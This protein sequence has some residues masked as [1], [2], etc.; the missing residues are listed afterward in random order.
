[1][2][3][4]RDEDEWRK[5][6][7]SK[8]LSGS[9][10][11]LIDNLRRRLESPAMS[12]A[13]TASIWEDRRLGSTEMVHIPV[14]CTWVATGNNPALSGEIA[15]R[16]VRIRLD[17]KVDR[18]WLRKDFRHPDL[19]SWS[20]EHR[21]DL[22]WAALTLGRAWLA[23]RRPLGSIA[24]GT[25]ENWARVIGGVLDVAKIPGFLANREDFYE[26]SDAEGAAWRAF[27]AAWWEQYGDREVGVSDLW[28]LLNPEKGD[29]IDLA[30]GDGAERS[31]RTRLGKMLRAMRDRQFDGL[32]IMA[33]GTRMRAQLWRLIHTGAQEAG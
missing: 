30:V 20:A 29:P 11:I 23:A 9:S 14:Q 12:A 2:T 4:G 27:V 1:M 6:I 22:I 16:T 33:A 25:F 3:E 5:R 31:Q 19:V 17:A 24:F 7:T 8:L 15:R 10:I 21:G 28:R 13:I 32:R 18:P 26:Q